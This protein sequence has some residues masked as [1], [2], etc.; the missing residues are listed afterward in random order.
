VIV[1]DA[2]VVAGFLFS[3]DKFHAQADAVR[4]RDSD[5]HCPE[6]VFSEVRSVAMKHRRKGD[7]LDATIARCNLT[8]AAVAVY[9]MH[10]HSVLHVA[11]EGGIWVYDAEYVALARQLQVKLVTTDEKLLAQFRAVAVSPAEFLKG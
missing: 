1:V 3:A 4:A 6:L 9:R 2:T 5:W 11:E 10:S 7:T 8:A